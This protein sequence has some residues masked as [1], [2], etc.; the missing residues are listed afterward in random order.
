MILFI[1]SLSFASTACNSEP[2]KCCSDCVVDDCSD[3]YEESDSV[4]C[5]WSGGCYKIFHI[6]GNKVC[7]DGPLCSSSNLD[8]IA[9]GIQYASTH[10]YYCS[11]DGWKTCRT[12]TGSDVPWIGDALACN[13]LGNLYECGVDD[14]TSGLNCQEIDGHYCADSGTSWKVA[15]D[16]E[17]DCSN[18]CESQTDASHTEYSCCESGENYI[19]SGHTEIACDT[20]GPTSDEDTAVK[21]CGTTDL[22]GSKI[23][24]SVND[25]YCDD[26]GT[27]AWII[28]SSVNVDNCEGLCTAFS[29]D[30]DGVKCCNGAD[31]FIFADDDETLCYSGLSHTCGSSKRCESHGDYLCIQLGDG[32]YA[33]KLD[34]TCS[35]MGLCW[36]KESNGEL[37]WDT[38]GCDA[39]DGWQGGGDDT[40]SCPNNDPA[41][42]YYDYSCS[43]VGTCTYGTTPVDCDGATGT[44]DD[45]WYGGGDNEGCGDDNPIYYRD[46][47]T[48][49]DGTC[50]HFILCAPPND[51]C[52]SRDLCGAHCTEIFFVEGGV[53][54]YW[55]SVSGAKTKPTCASQTAVSFDCRTLDSEDS[56]QSE[57]DPYRSAGFVTDYDGCSDGICTSTTYYDDCEGDTVKEV[58]IPIDDE[59]YYGID[60]EDCNPY[61]VC[62]EDTNRVSNIEYLV[63]YTCKENTIGG[64][65]G[66]DERD[67]DDDS[68][69]CSTCGLT[70][71][72]YCCG[73]DSNEYY[74]DGFCCENA[75]DCVDMDGCYY[76]DTFSSGSVKYCSSGTWND[77]TAVQ[78]CT[79][80]D[81]GT[82][83]FAYN[84][85]WVLADEANASCSGACTEVGGVWQDG[86]IVQGINCCTLSSK[87]S[88]ISS[89][90]RQ[91]LCDGD[92]WLDSGTLAQIYARYISVG[93]TWEECTS[94][95][96]GHEVDIGGTPYVCTSY[97]WQN[98]DA[99]DYG[100]ET[101]TLCEDTY[102]FTWVGLGGDKNC[103]GNDAS[104]EFTI[105]TTQLCDYSNGVIDCDSSCEYVEL[106]DEDYYCFGG[107]WVQNAE[108]TGETY[109]TYGGSSGCC[110]EGQCW[111]DGCSSTGVTNGA[112]LCSS[113][114]WVTCDDAL[115]CTSVSTTGGKYYCSD[116]I[117]S[118]VEQLF[119]QGT[120]GICANETCQIC[121]TDVTSGQKLEGYLCTSAGLFNAGCL[122]DNDCPVTGECS[123]AKCEAGS[124]VYES[125]AC[126]VPCSSGV[127]DGSG[128]CGSLG[129]GSTTCY[130]PGMCSEGF[131][132]EQNSCKV[133]ESCGDGVCQTGECSACPQDCSTSECTG[134]AICSYNLGENCDNSDD[135]V[136]GGRYCNPFSDDADVWGCVA[137][138]C[139]N[140][141]CEP[142]ECSFCADD[143]TGDSYCRR[144]GRCDIILGE[145]CDNS[146][147]CTC[148][149]N[150]TTETVPVLRV[151]EPRTIRVYLENNGNAPVVLDLDIIAE[152]VEVG[153]GNQK[154]Y[155][156]PNEKKNIFLEVTPQVTGETRLTVLAK[157]SSGESFEAG[158]VK[159]HVKSQTPWENFMTWFKST[160]FYSVYES[161]DVVL[162]IGAAL[163][164]FFKI[165]VPHNKGYRNYYAQMPRYYYGSQYA[166]PVQPQQQQYRR[167]YYRF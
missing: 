40:T 101:Q 143:C 19:E 26:S 37:V 136:C 4:D 18:A 125:E 95:I 89:S 81:I 120:T 93:A 128:N 15:S 126:G 140:G 142:S 162:G 99:A 105:S 109:L 87:E 149:I 68:I 94:A 132:C 158:E 110:A 157:S 134:D 5:G 152:G 138:A 54:Y 119:C 127:C 82:K 137:T 10:P 67:L 53:D 97:G 71:L 45:G 12:G 100:D 139:G 150:I 65:C 61:D 167:G 154:V 1:F 33:W 58:F 135:C 145:T 108:F 75:N 102:G 98:S 56:D 104:D 34:V 23:T 22:C 29:K 28:G 155:L 131:Y 14:T 57:P 160:P 76:S 133:A 44:I 47:Y 130:C 38:N 39:L 73:D 116:D 151:G 52:D 11:Q 55:P 114:D 41:A 118:Q 161:L 80:L 113:S 79:V 31:T 13:S 115:V 164:A 36:D 106:G 129:V 63:D 30:W 7:Q 50:N 27:P 35:S 49:T 83:Y 166:G 84:N 103:C 112:L 66:Y 48:G 69:Y 20:Y 153:G 91:Y 148:Q 141:I 43:E 17:D 42:T 51:F 121:G 163:F 74:I 2:L 8:G 146:P 117:W 88:I 60:E 122:A 46:Y 59:T 3:D 159:V 85:K 25:Y 77:A 70:W 32:T 72:S 90:G 107:V 24:I 96:E 86:T 16:V 78:A 124:C 156:S 147:D 6:L 21:T 64:Y 165:F 62:E 144:N 92:S 123:I 9:S 111:D